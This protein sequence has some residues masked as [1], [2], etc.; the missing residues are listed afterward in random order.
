[1]SDLKP[2]YRGLHA[3]RRGRRKLEARFAE[4]WRWLN[5]VRMRELMPDADTLLTYLLGEE[6]SERDYEVAATVI[7]W[8][9][10]P[11]GEA[12]AF[13]AYKLKRIT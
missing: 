7:A 1:M 13:D 2:R 10:S 11:A 3:K 9:G 5:E 6:P 8:L 4:R 12:F